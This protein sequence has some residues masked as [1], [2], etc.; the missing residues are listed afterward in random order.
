VLTSLFT[1]ATLPLELFAR[2]GGGGSG[3]GGSG[4]GSGGIF[5]FLGYIPMHAVGAVLQ[6]VSAKNK[7]L[8]IAINIIGWIIAVIYAVIWMVIWRGF[9][10][11]VGMAA[12]AGMA[13]G[14]Y[15]LFAKLKQS[16]QTQAELAAASANDTVWSEEKLVNHARQVFMQYQKDW[17]NLN[18]QAMQG[19]L[20]PYYY[21]HAALL[22]YTLKAMG[23]RD[24]MED[25]K[26]QNAVI[27][28]VQN[29]TDDS[30]DAFTIGIT[31]QA[32]DQLINTVT[33]QEIFT[34][35]KP[36]TE[37][38]TFQR[39]GNTWLLGGISQ[40]TADP[41]ALNDQVRTFA[42]NNGYYYS[43][44]MGWLFIPQHGQ[45]FGEAKFGTSD[46]N[47]H[48]VGMYNNQMLVQLYSYVKNPQS[49]AKPYVIAQVN[50]PKQYGNIIVR[51]KKTFRMGIRGL[52]KVETE[53]TQF[54]DKYEVFAS[55]AEQAT[56]FELLNP[57]YMEQLEALPFEVSIEVVD[58]VIYL[59]T[60]ELTATLEIYEAMLDLVN[61][62]FKELRY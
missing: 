18:I 59:Y 33:D 41:Y 27:L 15:N 48:I 2:A 31:A 5:I 3:G 34:D 57:T 42:A 10:F 35:R 60:D 30:R 23:R 26:I 37:Y 14:L 6:R 46:I 36:F 55:S 20:T 54:N 56:S 1:I 50:V 32:N 44:D 9:G 51:R 19:Y 13:G 62:A 61:K 24:N 39:S 16:K 28:G 17:S 38:W 58:N 45:L 8:K 7:A 47:N 12:L 49:S 4:D 53:W 40:A 22:A 21:N 11:F 25:V 43:L 29:D 52:E